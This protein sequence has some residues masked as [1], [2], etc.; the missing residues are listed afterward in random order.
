MQQNSFQKKFN[1]IDNPIMQKIVFN[2]YINR[3]SYSVISN[4]TKI[5]ES[6]I[7]KLIESRKYAQERNS[8]EKIKELRKEKHRRK[9][10]SIKNPS[11]FKK[12]RVEHL[13]L[14]GKGRQKIV[15]ETGYSHRFVE[16]MIREFI[17]KHGKPRADHTGEYCGKSI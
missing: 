5:E 15:D 4:R 16:N 14:S 10:R 11:P 12:K 13:W 8:F 3:D 17:V 9:F 1:N 6:D 7:K 2:L